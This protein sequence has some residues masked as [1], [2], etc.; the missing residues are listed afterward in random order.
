MSISLSSSWVIL[1][2]PLQILSTHVSTHF[3]AGPPDALLSLVLRMRDMHPSG[4]RG[5]WGAGKRILEG[6]GS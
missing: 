6:G 1:L 2:A 4:L 3:P 5:A